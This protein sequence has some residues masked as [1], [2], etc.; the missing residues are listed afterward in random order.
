MGANENYT[1][2]TK[3]HKQNTN[4]AWQALPSSKHWFATSSDK[5]K[6]QALVYDI[7]KHKLE[8]LVYDIDKHKLQAL[9][10]DIDKHEV[11]ILVYD[12][13]SP[14]VWHCHR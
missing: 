12:V 14:T 5:H 8:V 1:V 10:Y 13:R 2:T 11:K 6:L 7:D 9:V 4:A 3:V